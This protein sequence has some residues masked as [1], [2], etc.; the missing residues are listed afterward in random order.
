[1]KFCIIDINNLVHRSK[2]VIKNY[3]SFDECVGLVLTIVFNSIKK[4]YD[5]FGAEHCVACFDSYS[6][7]KDIYKIYKA[8][9][10]KDFNDLSPQ[11]I[12][13]H[14]II[15]TVLNDLRQFLKDFTNVTVL[16]APAVE[17]DDFIAR[18]VQLHIDDVFEHVII[19]G[20]G[21]FKQLVR[22]N[23]ELFNPLTPNTLYTMEGVFVFDGKKPGKNLTAYKHG[24]TWKIKMNKKTGKPETFEPEWELFKKC[25]RGD[26]SDNI[27]SA[28]P[29]VRE[30][31]MRKAWEDRGGLEWNNFINETWGPEDDRQSVRKRYELNQKLVDLTKQPEHIILLMD[32][33]TTEALNKSRKQMVGTYFMKFCS[34]YELNNLMNQSD[35]IVRILS[36]PYD[37]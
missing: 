2:H 3:D 37:V 29:R 26:S 8:N 4:T 25:I 1:M 16:D 6:W 32:E 24:Q 31:R 5:R 21:D 20:D 36:S 14:Q 23:V 22:K 9:R 12:E 13:E 7:R 27:K 19:S 15:K 17:A 10:E 11:K 34:R 18:W 28:F 30:T 35:S 33:T